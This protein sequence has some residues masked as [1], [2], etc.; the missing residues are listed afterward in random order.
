[1]PPDEPNAQWVRATGAGR[2]AGTALRAALSS[3]ART[4]YLPFGIYEIH[5]NIDVS[6]AVQRIVGMNSTIH[7]VPGDSDRSINDP[8]KGLLRTH[9]VSTPLLIEKLFFSCP[10][11][12][13]V[14]V[15]HSGSAPLVLRDIVGMGTVFQRNPEAGSLF[16]SNIS[17]GFSVHVAGHAP[18]WGRQVDSEGGGARGGT[19][20]VRITND[21]AP[22][23]LLGLKSEG[24]NTLVASSG[25][26]LTDIVGTLFASLRGASHP[27]F[28]SV[29]SSLVAAGVEIAWKPGASYH[30]LLL[31]TF[32]GR[33]FSVNAD[34]L[35]PRPQT[36]GVFLPRIITQ[37]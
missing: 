29:N 6:P 20:S 13:C 10:A 1:M 33:D 8:N 18:V 15:E 31:E 12:H 24:D 22:M 21:G 36:Q 28:V 34:M 16:L 23:W 5:G 37:N 4:I 32:K 25:G 2:D 9:N 26:A 3:G 7:W 19:A 35:P 30:T 11:G 27:L 17:G 14:A